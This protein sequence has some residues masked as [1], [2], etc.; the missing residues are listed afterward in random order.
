[1]IY[2]KDDILGS[3][4]KSISI[5]GVVK[6]P[7]VYEL[8]KNLTLKELFFI[9]GGFDDP[10][11][12]KTV[13]KERFDIIR[14]SKFEQK[15]I[16]SYNLVDVLKKETTI[17]LEDGDEI[18]VYPISNFELKKEIAVEGDIVSP[19][20]YEL[21]SNMTLG[22]LILTAGGVSSNISS[23]RADISR[24]DNLGKMIIFLPSYFLLI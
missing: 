4:E 14:K 15:K 13:L 16:L 6:R 9:S 10:E 7:G 24:I 19:G 20:N 2:S 17:Y 8:T 21:R 12:F 11:F 5:S 22:D 18:V 1:M 3:P 23:F